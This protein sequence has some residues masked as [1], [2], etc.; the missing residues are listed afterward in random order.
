[1]LFKERYQSMHAQV[2]PGKELLQATKDKM[3][4]A[5]S[6]SPNSRRALQFATAAC[7]VLAISFVVLPRLSNLTSIRNGPSSGVTFGT[8]SSIFLNPGDVIQMNELG[9]LNKEPFM[10]DGFAISKEETWSVEKYVAYLGIDPRNAVIPQGLTFVGQNSRKMAYDGDTLCNV[11]NTWDFQY[12]ADKNNT[13]AKEINIYTNKSFIP[14]YDAPRD[15]Q[16]TAEGKSLEDYLK[17]GKKS[18][19]NGT[20]V[21]LWHKASGQGYKSGW[22]NGDYEFKEYY[23][24]DF[25]YKDVGFTATAENGV[26]EQ[27]FI[28]LL[29]SI[30][31]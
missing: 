22:D 16:L 31:N 24:A 3:N 1:M 23:C 11:Y 21:T 14:Y 29:S 5:A 2:Q 18:T 10:S 6:K 19:I 27:E 15:N 8:T 30:I 9:E 12:K 7:L 20:E 28:T 4:L 25:W 13:H 17:T 26:T